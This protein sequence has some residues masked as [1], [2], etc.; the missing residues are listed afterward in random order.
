MSGR[1][2]DREAARRR[3][4]GR[5]LWI[6]LA[7]GALFP[8]C[9]RST[10]HD[11]PRQSCA[12]EDAGARPVDPALL[13]WLSKARTLHHLADLAESNHA[14]DQAIASLEELTTGARPAGDFPEVKEVL[15]D[16][17]ARLGELRGRRG[18]FDRAER[19]IGAGLELAREPTYFRGHLFEVR[20]LLYD[21]LSQNLEKSG[22]NAEANEAREKA[23]RAS[24]EAVRLQDEVI[25]TTLGDRP[26]P[27][28]R[29]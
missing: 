8:A 7:C 3:G 1:R 12:C 22:K 26:S 16:T 29:D 20:G 23:M 10:L 6:G 18:D 11:E 4:R 13:A 2:S 28:T 24:L 25:K 21:K 17:Y 27:D 5:V 9:A 14:T 15:A 19:D